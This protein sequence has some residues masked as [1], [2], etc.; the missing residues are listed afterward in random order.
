MAAPEMTS[1]GFQDE[2]EDVLQT[3]ASAMSHPEL[4]KGSPSSREDIRQTFDFTF[5]EIDESC[6]P[7][8][9][10]QNTSCRSLTLS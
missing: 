2:D 7:H 8:N 10:V 5:T 3:F 6:H 1:V 9:L 4:V